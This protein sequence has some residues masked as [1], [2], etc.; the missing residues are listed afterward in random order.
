MIRTKR[1]FCLQPVF[2]F[3]PKQDTVRQTDR[4]N[5]NRTEPTVS[6]VGCVSLVLLSQ[7]REEIAAIDRLDL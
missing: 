3:P 2:Q 6:A 4:T 1:D 5:S 7:S